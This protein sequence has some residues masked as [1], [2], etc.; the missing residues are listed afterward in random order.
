MRSIARRFNCLGNTN[1]VN[2][3]IQMYAQDWDGWL[4]DT[5]VWMD[6]VHPYCK[7]WTVYQCPEVPVGQGYGYCLDD[8]E[9]RLTEIA[10][11]ET[12]PLV[13]ETSDLSKS[14]HGQY[15]A[16]LVEPPRHPGGYVWI[17]YADGH[18][19]AITKPVETYQ[20]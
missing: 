12:Y 20:R 2:L 1:Q 6:L 5:E 7:T 11:R 4:P 17:G 10:H 9:L 14:A 16:M 8:A 15:P 13:F 3:S 19:K 18:G